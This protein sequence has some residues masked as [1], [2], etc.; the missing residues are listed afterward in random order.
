VRI[1]FPERVPINRVV[2]FAVVLLSIQLLEGTALY[3][4]VGC[5]I[6]IM[7]AAFAFNAAGGLSRASGA[8]IFSFTMLV[9]LVGLCYKAFLGQ[10]A[11]S[12]LL[13]PRTDIAAYI[14]TM[15]AMYAAV[16]VSRRLTRKTGLLQN[17]LHESDMYRASVGC[18]LFGSF[19]AFLLAILGESAIRLQTAFG[20]LNW[21][22]P[23]GII[24]GVMY[25]IRSSGGTKCSNLSLV[26]GSAYVFFLATTSFSKQGMILPLYCWALPICALRYRLSIVQILGSCLAVFVIFYWLVPFSQYGRGQVPEDATFA[27][28]ATIAVTLLEHPNQTR[29]AYLERDA[30]L[31]YSGLTSTGYYFGTPQGFWDRLQFISV[32]DALINLTDQGRVVGF[33]PIADSFVNV[34][35]HFI[36]PNRPGQRFGGN[37]YAHELGELADDDT[38]TGISFSPTAESYH[39]ARWTGIFLVAPLLWFMLF[40]ILDSLLGDIRLSPWGLLA[41][42]ML[43]HSAPEGG[44]TIV[45]YLCSYGVEILV[46]CALFGTWV[47]PLLATA[48]LGPKRESI[49]APLSF[50]SPLPHS[51]RV[52]HE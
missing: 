46:F 14:A 44:I 20:Q 5:L 1:P 30:F 47:A 43:S 7:V 36:W 41:M 31:T 40:T 13:V 23:L 17:M 2:I 26:I 42:A 37:Y 8:Y 3:F 28:R 21:L 48:V 52:N 39:I 16:L 15:V 6:F 18:M 51:P 9:V 50:P 11:Q 38:S 19:G 10:P 12:N 4:S 33:G 22:I 24:I 27:Q 29:R 32:D 45:P 25:E 35:P 49:I 34:V